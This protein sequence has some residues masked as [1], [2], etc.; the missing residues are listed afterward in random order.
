MP[1]TAHKELD[2]HA[3]YLEGGEELIEKLFARYAMQTGNSAEGNPDVIV[4]RT[5]TFTIDNA[6]EIKSIASEGR[7]GDGKKWIII[8]APF[9]ASEAEH[10]LLKTI[11]EPNQHTQFFLIRRGKPLPTLA[12]RLMKLELGDISG[13]SWPTFA[14]KFL[15]AS[16]GERMTLITKFLKENEE[17]ESGAIKEKV[18]A[19][20]DDFAALLHTSF[21]PAKNPDEF[22][23]ALGSLSEFRTYFFDRSPSIKMLLEHLALTLPI[24]S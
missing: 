3:Y 5:P 4:F 22:K 17:L 14:K 1:H 13:K 8:V 6:R 12:S 18:L 21:D 2:F 24:L 9:F 20:T 16:R 19:I 11:E 10:A 7:Y 23:A 15:S